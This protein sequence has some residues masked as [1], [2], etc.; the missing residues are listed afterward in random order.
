MWSPA[1][2]P[3][4]TGRRVLVTGVTSGIG[5]HIAL[6]LAR[7]GADV[8]LGGRDPSRLAATEELLRREVPGARLQVLQVDLASLA[9]I[10]EAAASVEGSLDLLVNNAGVLGG[11]VQRSVDGFEIH[12]AT[13]HLGPFALTGLLL[14]A[15]AASGDGRVVNTASASHRVARRMPELEVG[16]PAKWRPYAR[17]K[18]AVLRFTLELDERLRGAGMPVK[19]LAAHPGYAGTGLFERSWMARLGQSPAGGA[20]PTLMAATA[21][22]PGGA[23]VGPSYTFEMAGPPRVVGMAERARDPVSRRRLW[24]LSEQATGVR[25]L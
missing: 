24:E 23:Y 5:H 3:D 14:P 12:V 16:R 25:Y 20:Q 15:L 21:D 2:I 10:R 18:L 7:K 1:D 19:A 17:S 13:N 11:P 8:V 22:L 6:E 4:Q 9:S